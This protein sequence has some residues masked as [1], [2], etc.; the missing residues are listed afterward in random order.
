MYTKTVEKSAKATTDLSSKA[1]PEPQSAHA[2]PVV[3]KYVEKRKD[4]AEEQSQ[5]EQ[6]TASQTKTV[7]DE[8]VSYRYAIL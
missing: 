3:E 8:W 2:T 1:A 6:E 5:K 7:W 4:K